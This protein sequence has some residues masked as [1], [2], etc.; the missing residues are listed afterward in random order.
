VS[1]KAAQLT[2]AR[3][4]PKKADDSLAKKQTELEEFDIGADPI[5]KEEFVEHGVAQA[6]FENYKK[7]LQVTRV[8][9]TVM[10]DLMRAKRALQA[11]ELFE[12][13]D[14]PYGGSLLSCR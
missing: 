3:D 9:G 12:V 2:A 7:L 6:A 14:P 4:R 11:G 5:T 1:L 13:T 10:I 8:P